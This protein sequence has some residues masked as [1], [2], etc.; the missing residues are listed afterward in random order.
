MNK[1]MNAY[2]SETVF[3]S[4]MHQILGKAYSLAKAIHSSVVAFSLLNI[5]ALH[6]WG[7]GTKPTISY[8]FLN[9]TQLIQ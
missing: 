4:L 5:L 2:F 6:T 9:I 3:P 8:I 1:M 7:H